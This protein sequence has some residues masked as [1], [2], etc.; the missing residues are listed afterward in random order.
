MIKISD[1]AYFDLFYAPDHQKKSR[2]SV[3]SY[4]NCIMSYMDW[5]SI[6]QGFY[7]C[8]YF[9]S[10]S[11]K[12]QDT[13]IFLT[14]SPLF[15]IHLSRNDLLRLKLV[16]W[17]NYTRKINIILF[18]GFLQYALWDWS[19]KFEPYEHDFFPFHA[20]AYLKL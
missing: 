4:G 1:F 6:I 11:H 13:Y 8:Y 20:I 5:K 19:I 2:L 7:R 9:H 12:T 16:P 17:V 14:E 10:A 15:S 18:L 3:L